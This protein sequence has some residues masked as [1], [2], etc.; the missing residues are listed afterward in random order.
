MPLVKVLRLLE[1]ADN[2]T[3]EQLSTDT[4]TLRDSLDQLLLAYFKDA[5]EAKDKE[6]VD[7]APIRRTKKLILFILE[8]IQDLEAGGENRTEFQ[9]LI[10]QAYKVVSRPIRNLVAGDLNTQGGTI[11]LMVDTPVLNTSVETTPHI[12]RNLMKLPGISDASSHGP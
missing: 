1:D 5:K 6:P 12:R 11:E 4:K 10:D 7:I 9:N 8:R 2:Q 3:E